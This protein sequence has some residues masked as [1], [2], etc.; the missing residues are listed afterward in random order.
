MDANTRELGT[1]D[2]LNDLAE[3]VIGAAYEV[4][5]VLGA[6]FLEKVYARAYDAWPESDGAGFVAGH[7]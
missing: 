4:A 2:N 3:K 7:L 6:G 1:A 5:N